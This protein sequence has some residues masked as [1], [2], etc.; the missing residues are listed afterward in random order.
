MR[1][2]MSEVRQ[3]HLNPKAFRKMHNLRFLEVH[4]CWNDN[5]VHGFE[6]LKSDFS[7]LR[8]L[9]WDGY[10]AK[11]LPP[12]FN[13]K[14]LVALYMH[15]SNKQNLVNLKHI[16]LSYSKHL[17]SV[18]DLSLIPNL[19]S[20]ILEGCTNLHLSFSSNHNV[21]KLVLLNLRE[22]KNLN[23]LS[24]GTHWKYL[25]KLI[26][27]NCSNLKTVSYIPHTVE[28]LYVDGTAIKELPPLKDLSKL[29]ILNLKD[30]S[31][32]VSL[33]EST[34]ELK[35]LRQVILSN[36]SNLKT[37]PYIPCAV[38]EL[39]L[40]GTAIK[41][42][43]SLDHL[44]RLVK[45]SLKNCLRLESLPEVFFHISSYSKMVVFRWNC[46]KRITVIRA[47]VQT[48]NIGLKNCS[49]LESL[50]E[51]ICELKSLQ[52]L[53]LSDCSKLD[54]LP[55]S[56]GDL[57]ALETLEV[58]GIAIRELPSSITVK[59]RYFLLRSSPPRAC[60]CYPGSK[61]PEWFSFKSTG[62][63][64]KLP[65]GWLNDNLVGFT[66]CAAAS[67]R[68]YQELGTFKVRFRLLVNEDIVSSG[69]LFHYN[70]HEVIES[71]HVYVGYDYG[72]MSTELLTLSLNSE[73]HIVFFVE[74]GSENSIDFSKVKKCGVRL[75]YAKDNYMGA[76]A[77]VDRD[78]RLR[79]IAGACIWKYRRDQ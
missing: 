13:P 66:L 43:S 57:K 67:F 37:I 24:I 7:E 41:E 65:A 52:S 10:S 78:Q 16:D 69:D 1:L 62:F 14:N 19:E 12:N 59:R 4:G 40:D 68:D 5:K 33:P 38:E 32:L 20:L 39:Y 18:P 9:R 44:F 61:I 45:L 71:D 30:C 25:R 3:L 63:E 74:H 2:D 6:V 54:R 42:L 72:I 15:S 50:P 60:I 49:R 22:C 11:S 21:N 29:E 58:D 31:R 76:D 28:E 73:G 77:K 70:G 55:N 46:N 51:S 26:L 79:P 34:C 27:S 23:R 36:C 64:V 53:S 56:L 48:S 47:P 8:Y 35:S 17:R 75:L